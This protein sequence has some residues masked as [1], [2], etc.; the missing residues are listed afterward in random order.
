MINENGIYKWKYQTNK[1][2]EDVYTDF[3]ATYPFYSHEEYSLLSEKQKSDY[4][5]DIIKQIRKINIFP[6]I[7]FNKDGIKKEIKSVF[8]KND[9]CFIDDT[10]YTKAHQ[11]LL[12]LDFLFPNLHL[13]ECYRLNGHNCYNRF[14]D[15]EKLLFCLDKVFSSQIKV[16]N[17]RTLYFKIS[18]FYWATPINFA[19]VR[20]KAIYERFCPPNGVIYDYSAGYGGRMLGALSS[21]HNFTYIG[22]DPNKNTYYNLLQLG[23]YIEEFSHRENSYKIY[24]IQSERLLLK[25]KSV[26]FAFSCPPFFKKEFYSNEPTQSANNYPIYQDW[27]EY[28][29]RPTIKNC[30]LALKD[31]GVYG[32]DI[33]DYYYS[34]KRVELVK[35]WIRIAKEQGFI[36]KGQYQIK[37]NIRKQNQ[38]EG[39]KIYIFTKS[40]NIAIKD[41][42]SKQTEKLYNE[43]L[44]NFE[45]QKLRKQSVTIC[46]Y[47]VFGELIN[48]YQNYE[49]TKRDIKQLKSK[50]MTKDFKYFKIYRGDQQIVANI[51]VKKPICRIKNNYFFSMA[52]AGRF[53]KVSRQA[54]QQAR[55][56]TRQKINGYQIIWYD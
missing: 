34:G 11:G 37:S 43:Y 17:M 23:K 46:E 4:L 54:V 52:E 5:K 28:Y 39:E 55:K 7:Y 19:P 9:I 18:R 36:F 48:T 27:L 3:L 56:K 42:T 10:L 50:K 32:V 44:T 8:E 33:I 53:L 6:I 15:D 14:Y 26:D 21:S 12:L 20:A 35:D 13:A 40:E 51:E 2:K 47:D 41:Y 22:T 24:N 25:N 49:D 45:K 29:V 30:Y 16:L 31:D 1:Q 38:D